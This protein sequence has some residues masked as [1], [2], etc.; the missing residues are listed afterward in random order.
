MWACPLLPSVCQLVTTDVLC[1]G[2]VSRLCG[3]LAGFTPDVKVWEVVFSRS[4]EFDKL[5]RAFEL[6]GHTSGVLDLS[7]TPDSF[8]M[9]TVS[10]DG[11]WKLFNTNGQW[12]S[13][14]LFTLCLK[15]K[16]PKLS[17]F[18]SHV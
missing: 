1:V 10:R 9:A 2:G 8:R 18:T 13:V 14:G 12:L 11:T 16:D 5:S 17:I 6:K 15:Q 3:L 7:A 4:G